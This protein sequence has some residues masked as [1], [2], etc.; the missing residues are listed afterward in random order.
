MQSF[1]FE[2]EPIDPVQIFDSVHNQPYALFLDSAD[3]NHPAAQ[4]SFIFFNPIKVIESSFK[5]LE[6][7]Q[8]NHIAAGYFGYDLARELETLPQIATNNSALPPMGIGLY[9]FVME[10]DHATDTARLIIQA[11]NE[12]TALERKAFIENAIQ[13]PAPTGTP[14]KLDWQ[15]EKT[16]DDYKADVQRVI[17][18]IIEGDIFQ[19]NLSQRF[20]AALP[21]GFC[22]WSHYKHLRTINPAPFAAYMNL[23]SAQIISCSPERFLTLK[24]RNVETRPIKGTLP[25]SEDPAKLLA[26]EKDRAEN[27]MI[28]DLLRND[29]SKVCEPESVRVP[30]LCKLET[31][32][33]VHHLVSTV[34]GTLS[35]GKT[36]IDLLK[37]CFPG[38]SI[39]GAPKIRAMEIIEELEPQRRGPY[40]GAIGYIDANGDMDTNILIRT[41]IYENGHVS[42][43]AGGGITAS[44]K[45]NAEYQE[46][47]DKAAVMLESFDIEKTRKTG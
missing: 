17:D 26:S 2:L 10:F 29:L 24:G 16:P 25:R 14:Q 6:E 27:I 42:L 34:T 46:T 45:P 40:C 41:L 21:G 3:R 30:A 15:P 32:A 12:N 20:T 23:E 38:G 11:D 7:N 22:P 18:Y 13:S 36:A 5:N 9:D 37:A 35:N 4:K 44:S 1:I 39:T 19:A 47:L 31:F 8:N 33:S 43:N 28:V